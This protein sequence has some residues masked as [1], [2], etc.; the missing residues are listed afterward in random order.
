MKK[1]FKLVAM[2]ALVLPLVV[3]AQRSDITG[4][5]QKTADAAKFDTTR[6]WDI[7][8]PISV[9]FSASSFS[10]WAAG[11]VNTTSLTG[12]ASLHANYTDTAFSWM[13]DLELGYG[14]AKILGQPVQKTTDQ[15]E[16]TSIVGYK[17]FDHTSLAFLGNFQSQFSNGY[18]NTSDTQVISK[19]MAPGYL[20]ASLGLNYKP[21][22]DL[23]V[24]VSPVSARFV[25]V[26]DQALANAGDFGVQKAVY[27]TAGHIITPGKQELT[28]FGAYLKANYNHNFGKMVSLTTG[29]ELF[30]NYLKD[31][32]DIVVNWNG[33]LQVKVSKYIAVTFNIQMI[34]DN[35]INIAIYKNIGGVNTEVSDGP[36]LQIKDVLGVGI[37]FRI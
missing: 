26:E 15:I 12:L 10:N 29:I 37:G 20:I 30:S 19:F 9:A 25:F 11:G 5:A 27:D 7:G 28:E 14:F 1:N 4:A 21:N 6:K 17:V 36:R 18:S 3:S 22:K 2:V 8:G 34:Y 31:P 13:N 35:S 33:L 24:F 16:A 32:Q 23:N